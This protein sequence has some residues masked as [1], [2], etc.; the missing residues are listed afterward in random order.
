MNISTQIEAV[1][2]RALLLRNYA[3]EA[4]TQ[5]DLLDK[6]LSELYFVLEELQTSQEE[7]HQQNRELLTT[8]Q[9]V[10][11]ERQ[12]YQSLFQQAP[13]AYLV[14]DL[15]GKIYQANHHAAE[16]LL[17]ATQ[18]YLINKPL[19]VFVNK[20]DRP[21]FLTQLAN[22][23]SRRPWEMRLNLSNGT[24][25][26]V[27]IAITSINDSQQ[28]QEMLLWSLTNITLRKHMEQ[29]LQQAHDALELRVA[30][31]TVDL[32][33]ANAH[34]Q[35][36]IYERQQA[37]QKIR[38]QA[39]LIDI[40]ADAILV[41]DLNQTITFW[42]SGAALL[43]GWDSA[44][45]LAQPVRWLFAPDGDALS[46][47]G[48][49]NTMFSQTLAQGFWQSQLDQI[50]HS[51]AS[52]VVESRWT[53]M[54]DQAGQPQSI[55]VV[56]S[57]ITERKRLETQLYRAQRIESLGSLSNGIA[58][59]LKNVF[60]PLLVLSQLQLNPSKRF[61]DHNQE[62][63]EIIHRSA[64]QGADLV[65]QITLFAQGTAGKR[66]SLHTD[67]MLKEM[68]K[69]IERTFPKTIAICT[70]IP[71]EPVWCVMV[72]PTQL[73][74]VV[75]NLCINARD[76]MPKGGQLTLAIANCDVDAEQAHKHLN[77]RPGRYIVITVTDTGIGIP[78]A[79]VEGIFE[80]FFT[81]KAPGHGTGLGLSTVF[82]IVKNHNGFIEL[83]SQEGL[84]TQFH[85]YLPAIAPPLRPASPTSA[86]PIGALPQATTQPDPNPAPEGIDP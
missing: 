83:S 77:V 29:Q 15:Q 70:E 27:A 9:V 11:A 44:D 84:G 86:S 13:N 16:M 10:V 23:K 76:A 25:I 55:L 41:L 43:Y 74:Q 30:E 52:V 81:T 64:Q 75:L 72:N 69:T 45:I 20:H 21:Y 4:P 8:Q 7:L 71:T 42:N 47:D 28:Q 18:E 40:T 57:D 68:A 62:V 2:R 54:H 32:V 31:R 82:R 39:A 61:D 78:E 37:E 53:L 80:P 46:D 3:L 60:T 79:L 36:E 50:T 12:R 26:T 22:F 19:I 33:Q 24:V 6:A 17:C 59:D 48:I 1:Y 63:W 67:A 58:H 35:Q 56:N 73:H 65:E 66:I 14:T 38:D 51:G 85:I 34:L 5:H 49:L